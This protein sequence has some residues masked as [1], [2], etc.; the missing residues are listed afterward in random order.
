M[1]SAAGSVGQTSDD[2]PAEYVVEQFDTTVPDGAVESLAKR[3]ESIVGEL[4]DRVTSD[5]RLEELLRGQPGPDQL[6]RSDTSEGG[7]PEPFTQRRIIEPLFDEL[8]YPNFT[9]EATTLSDEQR[10]KADYLFSLREVDAIK[11][12]RLLVEAEP[13]NKKLDQQ[14][15]GL[16]QVKDWLDT[17]SFDADFGFATDGIR[18]V[19][20]KHDRERYQYDTLAEINL[21]P[22]FVAAFE[23]HTGRRRSVDEWLDDTTTL[24]LERFIRAFGFENFVAVASEAKRKIDDSKSA[25]TAEFYDQYVRRVFGVLEE[26]EDERT[27]FSL[28][29][30]GIIAPEAANGDDERLFAVELMNRLIFVKFLED[31]GLVPADLLADLADTY[32][33]STYPQSLYET[34]LEPLFFGV[35]DERPSERSEQIQQVGFYTDVP[36][37]NGGLFRPHE[38]TE[39]GFTDESFDVRDAVMIS[40]I[41]FLEAYTFSADGSPNDLD[42]SILGNV[43]E[44]TINYLTSDSSDSK[45]QLGAY[46][47]PDEITR[48]CAEGTVQPWLLERFQDIMVEDLGRERVDMERYDDLFAL[49]ERAVPQD[50]N[51]V[52]ALLADVDDLRALDPACGSGHFLTSVLGEI[53]TVRK[54]LY[55]KHPEDPQSWELHKQTVVENIYGVDIVEPAVEI[56]K[57]RL[58]LSIIAEVDSEEVEGYD[59]NELALPNVVFNVQHGNSLIGFTDLME[60]NEGGAQMRIDAWGP[61]TVRAKYEKVIDE[62]RQHKRASDTKVA[63]KHLLEAERLRETY[64]R[65]LNERVVEEFEDAGIDEITPE[66][67]REFEPF[68]WVLEFAGVYADGGFDVIVGNP[69]WDVLTANRS[70]FLSRYDSGFRSYSPSVKDEI[71]AEL[72]ETPEIAENYEQYQQG[73]KLQAEYFNDSSAYQ[74]Q[75]PSVDGRSIASENDL[76][77]LFLERVFALTG[78]DCWTSLVLPG[79]IFNGAASKDLRTK[80][81]EETNIQKLFEFEN[82]GIFEGLHPQYQ[83]GVITFNNNGA[84]EALNGVFRQRDLTILEE[85]D[86]HSITIPRQVLESYSPS[87]RIFPQIR[88]EREVDVLSII[89][90]H[91]P[92]GKRIHG[93]WWA[94]VLTKEIHEPTDKNRLF[95]DPEKGDYPVYTGN[96]IYQFQYDNSVGVDIDSPRLWS[97]ENSDEF[98]AKYRVRE[99]AFRRGRLKKA[100]YSEFGGDSTSK[101]QKSF[102]DDLLEERRGV[103]LSV[104]DILPDYSEYR[105]G[106]RAVTNSTN[107]RTMIATIIPKETPCVKTIQLLRPYTVSLT[108]EDLTDEPLHSA[109]KRVF[110]DREL[111]VVTG[112]MNSLPFDYLMRTKVATDMVK[113]KLEESQMPRLTEGDDW[114][115]YIS[116]RAARLNC[117]GDAFAEMRE[118]LG[119]LDPATDPEERERLRTEIDAAAFH[120]YGLGRDE[121]KFILDDFHRVQNPRLM[122]ESY[123]ERVLDEYDTLSE[124]GPFP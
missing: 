35:L 110:T 22:V 51:V 64:R 109:Y 108:E 57:L 50:A 5:N 79:V 78:E 54:A 115:E 88:Y 81:L 13:L 6:H 32:N 93:K 99:K 48:F 26:G 84:T 77:A 106:Y 118:R 19:L 71:E 15:H 68:H 87:A 52:E 41:E 69:P 53:V 12:S 66:Q 21:Q 58:W 80:L 63:R 34:F 59:E 18:W 120:A 30:D 49:I 38:N 65:E 116:T 4:R 94:D 10:Q 86:K 8:T 33:P 96:C 74:L 11:S 72:L 7:D 1:S 27:A 91:P 40:I 105:I 60:T 123:F 85:P 2:T 17:Y 104:D 29:E 3:I 55:E 9:T 56:A 98:S 113:Y 31:R 101:S 39:R 16:G 90:D 61:D 119:G 67:V 122:T 112:L 46:Y 117:Y 114:F 111:A 92:L 70:E 36:Y 124:S 44:K 103:G 47:T 76:S 42:P 121:T 83:F 20:I 97:V 14:K 25:A 100:I 43:F 95:D 75:S 102:T 23:N 73:I 45:K 37:L 62:I 82:H 107:E 24:L 89:L 28:V